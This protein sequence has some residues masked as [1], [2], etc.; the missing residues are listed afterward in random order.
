MTQANDNGRLRE[1]HTVNDVLEWVEE[2]SEKWTI[3]SEQQYPIHLWF[4]GNRSLG[5]QLVPSIFRLQEE[6]ECVKT[7]ISSYYVDIQPKNL[8]KMY[9]E[10]GLYSHLIK[11]LPEI[12]SE[13]PSVLDILSL[14][15]HYE[16]PCRL[17]DWTENVLIAL[18]MASEDNHK[19]GELFALNSRKLAETVDLPHQ[20]RIPPNTT[21][22]IPESLHVLLR[23]GMVL[24]SY[25]DELFAL[26]FVREG[27]LGNGFSERFWEH[28]LKAVS[29]MKEN[30]I[31]IIEGTANMEQTENI[32]DK[33]IKY[34]NNPS[35]SLSQEDAKLY[36]LLYK[37]MMPLMKQQLHLYFDNSVDIENLKKA[38]KARL[39]LFKFLFDLRKPVTVFP[40]RRNIRLMAQS[41]MFTIG[42]GDF[43]VEK[44]KREGIECRIP[45]PL[46]LNRENTDLI[47][48]ARIP[49]ECKKLLRVQL[50]RIGI[51]AANVYPELESQGKY[52]KNLWYVDIDSSSVR[53]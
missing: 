48:V 29:L 41:G 20:K 21:V 33:I 9:E 38:Q 18:W 12:R 15:R 39:W 2:V 31:G 14:F 37:E 52:L 1:I 45:R 7:Y 28:L 44:I 42:G 22:Y 32:I 51:H 6:K 30:D 35:N 19:D 27:F 8:S 23:T 53:G 5:H 25:L 36:K 49:R 47:R 34:I 46:H 10:G 26:P 13:F 11:R 50:E 43:L 4:R 24:T 40:E 3:N 16:L 17:L